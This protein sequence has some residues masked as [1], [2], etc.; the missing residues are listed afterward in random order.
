MQPECKPSFVAHRSIAVETA[1]RP[2]ILINNTK[3]EILQSYS[4]IVRIPTCYFSKHLDS[5]ILRNVP[6]TEITALFSENQ[7]VIYLTKK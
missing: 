7:S 3:R 2:Q 1:C 5:T 6:K 4:G